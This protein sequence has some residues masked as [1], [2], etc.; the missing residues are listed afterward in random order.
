MNLNVSLLR[1][2]P[3]F[4]VQAWNPYLEKD[5]TKIEN[6]QIRASKI[7]NGFCNLS[8]KEILK[9]SN[10]TSLKHRWVRADIIET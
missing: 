2:H 7:Y 3:E 10:I 8:Y 5:I 9:I 1:P 6:V 4:A